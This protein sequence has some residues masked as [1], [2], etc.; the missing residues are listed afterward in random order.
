MWNVRECFVSF[1][2]PR[3]FHDDGRNRRNRR[4]R[5]REGEEPVLLCCLYPTGQDPAW[6][7]RRVVRRVIGR[8]S[9]TSTTDTVGLDRAGTV[10]HGVRGCFPFGGTLV[11]GTG[12]FCDRCV[13]GCGGLLMRTPNGWTSMPPVPVPVPVPPHPPI[14]PPTHTPTHRHRHTHDPHPRTTAPRRG[15]RSALL[16]MSSQIGMSHWDIVLNSIYTLYVSYYTP[17]REV[18]SWGGLVVRDQRPVLN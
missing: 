18:R 11:L 8:R 5:R 12:L 7:R 4:R 2:C 6:S 16:F 1:E 3:D 10:D 15:R 14:P 17:E 13:G 9:D